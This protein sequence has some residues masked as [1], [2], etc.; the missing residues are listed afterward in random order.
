MFSCSLRHFDLTRPID[1]RFKHV[2]A[3][4]VESFIG[5]LAF[6]RSSTV[7]CGVVGQPR[8]IGP[9]IR[10][11]RPCCNFH[12]SPCELRVKQ[13]IRPILLS[14]LP[15]VLC[16]CDSLTTISDVLE[17]FLMAVGKPKMHC[18]DGRKACSGCPPRAVASSTCSLL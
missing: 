18:S 12:S 11:R 5:I 8:R 4:Y 15:L 13:Y 2:E 16:F 3:S 10:L 1:S 9:V 17:R 6:P 14:M 7:G